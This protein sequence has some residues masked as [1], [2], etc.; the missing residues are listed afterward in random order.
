MKSGGVNAVIDKIV[1]EYH[2]DNAKREG[3]TVASGTDLD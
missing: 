1:I 3:F 2:I